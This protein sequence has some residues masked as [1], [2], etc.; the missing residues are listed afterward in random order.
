M[1][2]EEWWRSRVSRYGCLEDTGPRVA[3]QDAWAAAIAETKEACAKAAAAAIR[4][5]P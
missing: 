4:A 1:T 2:F 5:L 3:A